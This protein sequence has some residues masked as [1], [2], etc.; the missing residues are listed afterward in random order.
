VSVSSPQSRISL[1]NVPKSTAAKGIGEH[2]RA[3]P[4]GTVLEIGIGSEEAMGGMPD[5]FGASA[6][7]VA[8]HWKEKRQ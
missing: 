8:S 3:R 4:A 7:L 5:A 1:F 6:A 2:A